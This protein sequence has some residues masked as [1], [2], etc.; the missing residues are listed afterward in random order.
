MPI[1]LNRF[2]V[3]RITV[4]KVDKMPIAVPILEVRHGVY[5][6][7][8]SLGSENKLHPVAIHRTGAPRH[9]CDVYQRLGLVKLW[10]RRDNFR[11]LGSRQIWR[12][13]SEYCP[14]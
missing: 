14:E 12:M 9:S 1:N 13:S 4:P 3:R 6:R 7:P 5:V 11:S 2:D 8:R 10:L